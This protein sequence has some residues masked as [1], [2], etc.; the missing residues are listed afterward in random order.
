MDLALEVLKRIANE[1]ITAEQ[2]SSVKSYLKGTFP[3]E[4]LETSDQLAGVIG[5]LEVYGLGKDYIDDLFSR[6]DAV[7]LADANAIARKYYKTGD[8]TFVLLGNAAKIRDVA[9]KYA[10]KVTE[11][12]ITKPG[13]ATD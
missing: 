12:A 5:D 11:I 7:S 6:I 8:L 3:A 13:I 1:G 9:K 4:R 2:L 10:P